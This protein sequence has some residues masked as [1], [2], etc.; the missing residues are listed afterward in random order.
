MAFQLL[1][2]EECIIDHDVRIDGEQA[3]R[4]GETVSIIDVSPDPQA[5]GRKYLV[6]STALNRQVRLVGAVLRRTGC[7]ECR[8]PLMYP[9]DHCDACGWKSGER[10]PE[11][12]T[13]PSTGDDY[14]LGSG[15]DVFLG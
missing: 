14:D 13:R 8:E 1:P 10:E 7:P 11:R 2:G 6:F 4:Q 9:A 5:P 12:P 3:F 15:A